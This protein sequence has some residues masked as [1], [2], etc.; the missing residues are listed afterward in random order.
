MLTSE[1]RLEF[2]SGSKLCETGFMRPICARRP[3]VRPPLTRS[4]YCIRPFEKRVVLWEHLRFQ[5]G[6]PL[7]QSKS[8]YSVFIKAAVY[9]VTPYH[10]SPRL[11]SVLFTEESELCVDFSAGRSRAQIQIISDSRTAVSRNTIGSVAHPCL[12]GMVSPMMAEH[13]CTLP[14][15]VRK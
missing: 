10:P 1:T 8:F 14:K 11:R 13:T 3:A 12:C 4:I 15:T 2:V 5:A 7:S 9:T 6:F